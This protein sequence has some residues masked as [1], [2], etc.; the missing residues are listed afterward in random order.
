M[1]PT[2]KAPSRSTRARKKN[3]ARTRSR[4]LLQRPQA[5]RQPRRSNLHSFPGIFPKTA[6]RTCRGAVLLLSVCFA[7]LSNMCQLDNYDSWCR[8]ASG[9]PL[10]WSAGRSTSS[11]FDDPPFARNVRGVISWD[12]Y[13]TAS[14]WQF[15]FWP[16]GALPV[17]AAQDQVHRLLLQPQISL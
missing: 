11:P 7:H 10:S 16:C 1:A 6:L 8:V 9:H 5:R 14:C 17:V 2:S 12:V 15:S 4:G 13:D 3:P